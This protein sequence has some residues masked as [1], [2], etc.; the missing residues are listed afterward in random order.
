MPVKSLPGEEW[1]ALNEIDES[2]PHNVFVSTKGRIKKK[3][4]L[5][6]VFHDSSGY[7]YVSVNGVSLWVHILVAKAFVPNPNNLPVVDHVDT[8]KDNC[9]AYNLEWVTHKENTQ[10]F[11]DKLA[12]KGEKAKRRRTNIICIDK[13][14][15]GFLYDNQSVAARILG[16]DVKS[17]NKVLR[18][19]LKTYKGYKFF[20][21]ASLTD[22]RGQDKEEDEQDG[23]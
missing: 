10:R 23:N 8:N 21:I 19:I 6:T 2:L 22:C 3:T 18:G 12:E 9:A 15:K 5:K 20:R 13:E 1:K 4:K 14:D 17:I 7:K 11:Y 16:I